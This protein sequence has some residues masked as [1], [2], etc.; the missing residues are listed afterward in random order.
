MMETPSCWAWCGLLGTT[1]LALDDDRALVRRVDAGDDLHQR[2]LAGAVFADQGQTFARAN[3]EVDLLERLHARKALAD[4]GHLQKNRRWFCHPGPVS[5]DTSTHAARSRAVAC[6]A[7]VPPG[8]D[9]EICCLVLSGRRGSSYQRRQSSA[10]DAVRNF[11]MAVRHLPAQ[12]VRLFVR[13]RDARTSVH[14]STDLK[15]T[16]LPILEQ[17][18][19]FRPICRGSGANLE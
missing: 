15:F 5:I 17:D 8:N 16:A 4:A 14:T 9:P 19:R 10:N 12:I 18:A 13:A 6:V 11:P 3:V 1:V 2:A 7:N